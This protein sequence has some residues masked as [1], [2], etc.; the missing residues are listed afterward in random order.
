MQNIP[1]SSVV[2]FVWAQVRYVGIVGYYNV[3]TDI[4]TV[5]LRGR[6]KIV[7]VIGKPKNKMNLREFELEVLCTKGF[8]KSDKQL[9]NFIPGSLKPCQSCPNQLSCLAR[10]PPSEP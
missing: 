6:H 1:T 9:T 2:T 10:R 7:R 3:Y 4:Y 8:F 5:W